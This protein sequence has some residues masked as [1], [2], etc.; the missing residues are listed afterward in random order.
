MDS[1]RAGQKNSVLL[2]PGLKRQS[3]FTK[4]INPKNSEKE[5]VKEMDQDSEIAKNRDEFLNNLDKTSSRK[6]SS[7][8]EYET[9]VFSKKMNP[10][11]GLDLLNEKPK[12]S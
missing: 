2:Q 9:I 12:F 8:S 5:E 6:S 7:R 1:L 10:I 11:S 4:K 3:T